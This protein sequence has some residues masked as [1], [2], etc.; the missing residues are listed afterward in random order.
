MSDTPLPL[1]SLEK[2][3]GH[4]EGEF[5]QCPMFFLTLMAGLNKERGRKLNDQL[6][7]YPSTSEEERTD[8]EHDSSDEADSG[9]RASHEFCSTESE[10]EGN[11]VWNVNT[12]KNFGS[13]IPSQTTYDAYKNTPWIDEKLEQLMEEAFPM[14]A[15]EKAQAG[16]G[17]CPS[18]LFQTIMKAN[19]AGQEGLSSISALS[20]NET[21]SAKCPYGYGANQSPN[22]EKKENEEKEKNIVVNSSEMKGDI[23][24]CPHINAQND[25]KVIETKPLN[26]PEGD[27]SKCP[28]LSAQKK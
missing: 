5:S 14:T 23:S 11:I 22:I 28:H 15:E 13:G 25:Q 16:R 19:R 10:Q 20:L 9:S 17:L 27:I 3:S 21:P 1:N 12:P 24:K 2:P 4:P 8:S 6:I 26:H 7:I 18:L